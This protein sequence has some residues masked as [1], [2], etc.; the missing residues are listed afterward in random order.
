MHGASGQPQLPVALG[1]RQAV[2]L[3]VHTLL[4]VAEVAHQHNARGIGRP[5]AHHPS[6][7]GCAVQAIIVVGVG[8]VGKAHLATGEFVDF[9][10]RIGMAARNG[11]LKR[12]EPRVVLYDFES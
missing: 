9:A 5:L 10:Q 2:H 7:I 12:R 11:G 3:V 6:A 1:A 8:P 4:P